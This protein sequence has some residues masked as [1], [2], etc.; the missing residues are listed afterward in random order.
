MFIKKDITRPVESIVDVICDSCG[1]SCMPTFKDKT[2]LSDVE[3]SNTEMYPEGNTDVHYHPFG[4]AKS[5]AEYL[6]IRGE[7]GY[8]SNQKD[9]ERWEAH[10]CEKCVDEKLG[11]IKFK[12]SDYTI[13]DNG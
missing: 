5:T 8:L 11:F 4:D 12:K 10:V 3:R 9:T 6:T 2:K 7:W 13:K 1:K